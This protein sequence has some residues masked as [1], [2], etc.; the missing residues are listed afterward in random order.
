TAGKVDHALS[1]GHRGSTL[2]GSVAVATVVAEHGRR[3]TTNP[4]PTTPITTASA[5]RPT[6]SA[7]AARRSRTPSQGCEGAPLAEALSGE[8]AGQLV[9]LTRDLA[10]L[11]DD[12]PQR[13]YRHRTVLPDR[14]H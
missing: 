14:D 11:L 10:S 8:D 1:P 6:P 7:R 12:L 13:H 5:T 9:Q 3:W 4:V 2:T